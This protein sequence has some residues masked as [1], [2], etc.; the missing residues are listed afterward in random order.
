MWSEKGTVC[1]TLPPVL[2]DYGVAFRV[3]H[4]YSS[5]SVVKIVAQESSKLDEPL[6][7]FYVGDWD[8]SGLHMSEVDLPKRLQAYGGNVENP[9][10]SPTPADATACRPHS[11]SASSK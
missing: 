5:A 2:N 4:G 9:R 6:L 8:P 11:F 7:V 1:G 3:M 10:P